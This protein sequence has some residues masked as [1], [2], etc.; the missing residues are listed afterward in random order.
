MKEIAIILF[1]ALGIQGIYL[2]S[3]ASEYYTGKSIHRWMHVYIFFPENFKP[4]GK[5]YHKKLVANF[6]GCCV[7]FII[8]CIAV[9]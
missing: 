3:K 5:H 1:I 8:W 9:G 7:T 6:I 4:E 2:E